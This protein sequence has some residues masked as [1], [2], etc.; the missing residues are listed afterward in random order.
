M[1][2][3]LKNSLYVLLVLILINIGFIFMLMIIDVRKTGLYNQTVGFGKI[4]LALRDAIGTSKAFDILSTV[5]LAFAFLV[6]GAEFVYAIY[7]LIKRKSLDKVDAEIYSLALVY[8]S[9]A[10]V[11]AVFNYVFVIN[12][13]PVVI[14]GKL[15]SSF[16]STHT[17]VALTIFTT[18]LTITDYLFENKKYRYISYGTFGLLSVLMVIF[19]MLSGKHWF[20]DIVGGILF[21]AL[22]YWFHKVVILGIKESR[23]KHELFE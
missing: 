12:N 10:F 6:V 8:V 1:S 16:P 13:R 18:A 5:L 7:Q 4:N 2:K 11:F 21:A 9:L 22:F 3:R 19:R 20:T 15:E 17:M 23:K 14:D